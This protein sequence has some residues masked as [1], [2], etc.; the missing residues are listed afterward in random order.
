M[1]KKGITRERTGRI[2]QELL[3][4]LWAFAD[5]LNAETAIDMVA[6]RLDLTEH[7]QG[8]YKN[9]GRRFDKILLFCTMD[10]AKAGWMTKNGNIWSVT[11]QGKAALERYPRPED[12]YREASRLYRQW[13]RRQ[14]LA[15]MITFKQAETQAW[16]E[17]DN[18]FEAMDPYA[19]QNLVAA[20]LEAMG[21]FVAWASPPGKDGGVAFLAW[22]EPRGNRPPS[23]KVQVRRR[24]D[25]IAADEMH[26][27][28]S[29]INEDD[30]GIFV[31]TG[32]FSEG[33]QALAHANGQREIKLIDTRRLVDLWI[34]YAHKIEEEKRSLLPLRPIYFLAPSED[35]KASEHRKSKDFFTTD[36]ATH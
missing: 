20:L 35:G 24:K 1:G 17:L 13:R 12:F 8:A 25:P 23:I 22:N 7:E 33:A 11:P 29:L 3:R 31:A 6:A 14:E 16:T 28:L 2:L 26:A 30:V 36:A 32:G 15:T 34:E 4:V 21:Y 10:A 19:F 18:H 9:G 5:G 27:F